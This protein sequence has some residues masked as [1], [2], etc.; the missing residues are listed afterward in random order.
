MRNVRVVRPLE[1]YG[2]CGQTY[3]RLEDARLLNALAVYG[4]AVHK[5]AQDIRILQ[6][7]GE[8]KEAF[9]KDQVSPPLLLP[10]SSW[11]G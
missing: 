11:P 10:A 9:G 4:A 5:M 2:V 6:S 8:L 1:A 3:P 7:R